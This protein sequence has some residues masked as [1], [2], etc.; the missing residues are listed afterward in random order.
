MLTPRFS[1]IRRRISPL[2]VLVVL[3][4]AGLIW[5]CKG[6]GDGAHIT[7]SGTIE[8]VE[9]SVAAKSGGQIT[10]LFVD[11]GSRV[12][13]GDT[14]A[15][16][17][18]VEYG[19]NYRQATAAVAMADA[20]LLMFERGSR[21]EDVAQAAELA[22]QAKVLAKNAHEDLERIKALYATH[23]VPGKSVGDAEARYEA[24]EAGYK[25]AQQA[26]DRVKRGPRDE[27]VAAAR[28]RL[29]QAQAQAE[30]FAKKL[31]DCVVLCPVNGTVTHRLVSAG[32][33]VAPIAPIVTVS[34]LDTVKLTIYVNDRELGRVKLGQQAD[35]KIDALP[36]KTF[37]GTVIYVSPTAEFTP[38][39]VQTKEDR[40]K[41][42]FAV[43]IQ[44]ANP[45]GNL[46]PGMPADATLK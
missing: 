3:P 27:D 33:Q 29:Q 31:A 40:E 45:D 30:L 15:I 43:K 17:D 18:S 23:A 22:T 8:V 36:D 21:A 6:N 41:L 19:M 46:K 14:I 20:Q 25:A 35:V 13:Q 42:V 39:N 2:V 7:A 5:S 10:H 38:K 9:V 32:E 37:T 24:A 1:S 12:K 34:A 28:A 26:A 11:E 16:I 44:L 4:L